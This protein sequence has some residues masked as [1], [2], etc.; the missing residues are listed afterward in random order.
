MAE[1]DYFWTTPT[2]QTFYQDYVNGV[3]YDTDNDPITDSVVIEIPAF[4]NNRELWSSQ[5]RAD[6]VQAL[7]DILT[8]YNFDSWGAG[9]YRLPPDTFSVPTLIG[10]IDLTPGT[11]SYGGSTSFT[12]Y[13]FSVEVYYVSYN[14]YTTT[15]FGAPITLTRYSIILG[16]PKT[17]D[18]NQVVSP[19]WGGDYPIA[20]Q[21][22]NWAPY[23]P[24]SVGY[25]ITVLNVVKPTAGEDL[26]LQLART[27]NISG[28]YYVQPGH[29]NDLPKYKG[30]VKYIR[31]KFDTTRIAIIEDTLD[32]GFMIYEEV[33]GSP[34]GSAYIYSGERKLIDVVDAINVPQY[35]ARYV[36]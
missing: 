12:G 2:Q 15:F 30:P 25:A 23:D 5:T 14:I 9:Y 8:Q 16:I 33:A 1:S 24:S 4:T 21:A 34:S 28:T 36:P 18:A 13:T 32:G 22:Y 6:A 27:G 10:T 19:A 29:E 7:Q 31:A 26:T 3:S 11:P 17:Y 20:P 35:R